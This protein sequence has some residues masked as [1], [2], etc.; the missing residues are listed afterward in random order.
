M[1]KFGVFKLLSSLFDSYRGNGSANEDKTFSAEPGK[2][3]GLGDLLFSFLGK[4][5]AFSQN[6]NNSETSTTETKRENLAPSKNFRGAP[7]QNN[8]LFTMRSHDAAVK[9]IKENS[10]K[11]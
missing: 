1:E 9:R 6:R 10:M 4:N 8:M 7:L 3:K 2:N 5:N 11:K